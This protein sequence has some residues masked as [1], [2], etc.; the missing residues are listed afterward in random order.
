MF[1][2]KTAL[3]TIFYSHFIPH[4][5][6]LPAHTHNTFSEHHIVSLLVHNIVCSH[7]LMYWLLPS[8][9]N[10]MRAETMHFVYRY[11]PPT[12]PSQGLA[13]GRLTIVN[14]TEVLNLRSG[15]EKLES[16][17]C[18]IEE[19][20]FFRFFP[21]LIPWRQWPKH[22]KTLPKVPQRSPPC[23]Y[24]FPASQCY[25]WGSWVGTVHSISHRTDYYFHYNNQNSWVLILTRPSFASFKIKF[26]NN[27]TSPIQFC[28]QICI[29]IL[30]L[31]IPVLSFYSYN[32]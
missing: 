16:D 32:K 13:Y 9:L 17:K 2:K 15:E 23:H 5:A 24:G 22:I 10:S 7:A 28:L 30:Y 4:Q 6:Q 25:N 27:S 29:C 19:P 21:R 14:Q 8:N 12:F 11:I 20:I 3:N 1:S 18:I 31:S 26:K